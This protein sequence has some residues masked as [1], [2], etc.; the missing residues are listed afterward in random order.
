MDRDTHTLHVITFGRFELRSQ[1]GPLTGE[2]WSQQEVRQLFKLLL[3]A[4]QHRLHLDQILDL[5]WSSQPLEYALLAFEETLARL[6][7][8]LTLEQGSIPLTFQHNVLTLHTQNLFI[9]ADVFEQ[10]VQQLQAHYTMHPS[11]P[12]VEM[13][14]LLNRFEQALALYQGDYLP[15]ESV[16]PWFQPRRSQFRSYHLWL[17]EHISEV[18]DAC[19]QHRKAFEYLHLLRDRYPADVRIRNE[20]LRHYALMERWTDAMQQ[21]QKWQ[22]ETPPKETQPFLFLPPLKKMPPAEPPTIPAAETYKQKPLNSPLTHALTPYVA[23]FQ[24]PEAQSFSSAL[25]PLLQHAL[26]N[27]RG[28]EDSLIGRSEEFEQLQCFFQQERL[29]LIR[30]EAGSGKTHLARQFCQWASTEHGARCFWSTCTPASSFRPY[31]PFIDYLSAILEPLT[32]GQLRKKYGKNADVFYRLLPT[33]RD[34]MKS[35]P[36]IDH[37]FLLRAVTACL[38]RLANQEPVI[39]VL[40][41]AQWSDR[42]TLQ[43]LAQLVARA[44]QTPALLFLVLYRAEEV[45]VEHPLRELRIPLEQTTPPPELRLSRPGEMHTL[46]LLSGRLQSPIQL[47]LAYVLYKYTDGNPCQTLETLH[48]LQDTGKLQQQD[49]RWQL[50]GSAEHLILPGSMQELVSAR[51]SQCT[52]ACQ[53]TLAFAAVQGYTFD[54][55]TLCKARNLPQDDILLHLGQ[56]ACLHLIQQGEEKK[57]FTFTHPSIHEALYWSLNPWSK[58]AMHREIAHAIEALHGTNSQEMLY[59]LT[60]H[61]QQAEEPRSALAYSI[62]LVTLCTTLYAYDDAACIL[63]RTLPLLD[64]HDYQTKAAL[65]DQLIRELYLPG[66]HIERALQACG[67][68]RSLWHSLKQPEKEEAIIFQQALLH[69]RLRQDAQA[70]QTLQPLSSE[71]ATEQARTRSLAL[72][73]MLTIRQGDTA[74]AFEQLRQAENMLDCL[75]LPDPLVSILTLWS[76][77]WYSFLTGSPQAMLSY[78]QRGLQLCRNTQEE[79]WEPVHTFTMIWALIHTGYYKKSEQVAHTALKQAQH[80]GALRAR[81]WIHLALLFLS[82]RREHWHAAREQAERALTIARHRHDID[83]ELFTLWGQSQYESGQGHYEEA[84]GILQQTLEYIQ[85]QNLKTMILPHLQLQLATVH[86]QEGELEEARQV[87]QQLQQPLTEQRYIQLT[88]L[89]RRLQGCI[90]QRLGDLDSARSHF[91]QTLELLMRIKDP[92]EY[93]STLN[94]LGNY[95]LKRRKPGDRK[96]GRTY[97][98]QAKS[99]LKQFSLRES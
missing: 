10:S 9:D 88:A 72:Q 39:I 19:H 85:Q 96:K 77:S 56:A 32:V 31:K 97:L 37:A 62:Q 5:L 89:S 12:P 60:Y 59:L 11:Q 86:Y 13:Q 14:S 78:A 27:T 35:I 20:L 76:R 61:Y 83:L 82:N 30:G 40:D 63:E 52:T 29:V 79:Y 24:F 58:R 44:A 45:G 80:P 6:Q 75:T 66:G 34:Q 1:H 98:E 43:L 74:T 26:E 8:A 91:E 53:E 90:L 69:F 17:L 54:L 99:I 64:G 81:G 15:E 49:G 92:L 46:E 23:P 33:Y 16:I 50:T 38:T 3:T 57:E 71:K 55:E 47:S 87:L 7:A 94:L 42:S 70:L 22:Q 95:Y 25:P 67:E 65:L 84:C 41:N 4:R 2:P 73:S 28:Q 21:V 93:A 36:D 68:A 48:Y 18:A 51:L